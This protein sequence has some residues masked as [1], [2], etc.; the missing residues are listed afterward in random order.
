[1]KSSVGNFNGLNKVHKIS[2]FL[3]LWLT[4]VLKKSNLLMHCNMNYLSTFTLKC[5]MISKDYKIAYLR[6]TTWKKIVD[7]CHVKILFC[8]EYK[9][10]IITNDSW[11]RIEKPSW[12]LSDDIVI[13]ILNNFTYN[14]YCSVSLSYDPYFH[15]DERRML[16]LNVTSLNTYFPWC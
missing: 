5:D 1:M 7:K 9:L 6:H 10:S 15:S 16:E 8:C 11:K 13:C 4:Y 14:R 12:H 3:A 2:L